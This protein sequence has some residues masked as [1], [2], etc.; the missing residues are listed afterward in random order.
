MMTGRLTVGAG[1]V[2]VL[3]VTSCEVSGLGGIL[4][5]KRRTQEMKRRLMI[6]GIVGVE[7]RGCCGHTGWR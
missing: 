5:E 4:L 2:K 1:W 7:K 3:K 6:V